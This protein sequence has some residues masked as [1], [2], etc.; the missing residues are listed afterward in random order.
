MIDIISIIVSY[1]NDLFA[2]VGVV[3]VGLISWYLYF[4]EKYDTATT[5][6]YRYLGRIR[7]KYKKKSVEKDIEKTINWYDGEKTGVELSYGIDIQWQE[8]DPNSYIQDGDVVICLDDGEDQPRNIALAALEYAESA[9]L[10]DAKPCIEDNINRAINYSISLEILNGNNRLDAA[11]ILKDEIID[12]LQPPERMATDGGSSGDSEEDSSFRRST[13]EERSHRRVGSVRSTPDRRSGESS[14]KTSEDENKDE[15]GEDE[16]QSEAEEGFAEADSVDFISTNSRSSGLRGTVDAMSTYEAFEMIQNV[17]EGGFFGPILL[18]EYKKLGQYFPPNN[19]IKLE[20]AKALAFVEKHAIRKRGED[21]DL[22]FE[23]N[24]YLS[25]TIAYVGKWPIV[26][27]DYVARAKENLNSG[28]SVYLLAA[29]DKISKLEDVQ[30]I[31]ENIQ[32]VEESDLITY[33]TTT[34]SLEPSDNVACIRASPAQK[35]VEANQP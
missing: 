5:I 22:N 7:N 35:L 19:S 32:E 3:S 4:P 25:F 9:V 26:V 31:L 28:N 34:D 33:Q 20:S 10:P 18:C 15:V 30:D 27:E 6:L 11:R 16:N 24:G 2:F 1:L 8:G 12:D 14:V 17:R 23:G 29:D 13:T 21:V